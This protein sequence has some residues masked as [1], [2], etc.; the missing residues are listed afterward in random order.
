MVW[1]LSLSQPQLAFP[2][3]PFPCRVQHSVFQHTG[4]APTRHAWPDLSSWPALP[5]AIPRASSS[6]RGSRP[7]HRTEMCRN[8]ST[9][10]LP[11]H[12][13]IHTVTVPEKNSWMT[14]RSFNKDPWTNRSVL[15]YGFHGLFPDVFVRLRLPYR[16]QVARRKTKHSAA[17]RTWSRLDLGTPTMPFRTNIVTQRRFSPSR[18]RLWCRPVPDAK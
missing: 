7:S 3:H 15:C 6:V 2:S 16:C 1:N 18:G 10:G 9:T 17:G 5:V 12:A 13:Q 8:G 4:I 14:T 11:E